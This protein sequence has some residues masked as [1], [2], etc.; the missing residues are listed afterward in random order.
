MVA[1]SPSA[2]SGSTIVYD[3]RVP[4]QAGPL[5]VRYGA[6][7]V[8][9]GQAEPPPSSVEVYNWKTA[10]WRILP[11]SGRPQY[12]YVE[13]PLEDG[14]V[15]EGLVRVRQRTTVP[16]QGGAGPQLILTSASTDAAVPG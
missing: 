8:L 14:E 1:A 6:R 10:G 2:T 13:T 12:A 9:P 11:G 7:F 16:F 3:M 4:P 5:S 15:N